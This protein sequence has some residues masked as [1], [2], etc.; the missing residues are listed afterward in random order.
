MVDLST[1]V[2]QPTETKDQ[3]EARLRAEAQANARNTKSLQTDLQ[4]Q[5]RE[6]LR[7][8]GLNGALATAGSPVS[9]GGFSSLVAGGGGGGT[10]GGGG[11]GTIVG[12]GGGGN[13]GIANVAQ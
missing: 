2:S 5:T 4:A 3:K 1:D 9:G 7:R 10:S 6:F 8:F 12:G 11:G 13:V